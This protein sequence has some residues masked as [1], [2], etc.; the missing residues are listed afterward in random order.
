MCGIFCLFDLETAASPAARDLALK[1]AKLLRHRGPDW[2]GILVDESAVLA[3]ERL[4]IVDV[5][6]GA[7]PL[8]SAAGTWSWRSTARSTTTAPCG[9]VPR[10][11][12]RTDSDCEPIMP[13]YA[14]A[15]V[16]FLNRLQRHFRFR[17]VRQAP[18]R[19]AH[20]PRPDR[21]Q[22]LYAGR[23]ETGS[24]T[25][26]SEMKA[27]VK[28]CPVIEDF[29]PGH[30]L[31]RRDRQARPLLR[32]ATGSALRRRRPTA[33]SIRGNSGRAGDAVHSAADV[34]RALRR[35]DL[36]RLD[37]SLVAAWP[38]G[39]RGSG[40]R[41]ATGV[42]PGGRGST[43]L[44]S[45]WRD[46]PTWP[47]PGAAAR[48]RQRPPRVSSSP[49]GGAGRAERCHLSHRMLRRRRRSAPRRRCS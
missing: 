17:P 10:L 25:V 44:R 31:T 7:Q 42:R 13:L 15:R 14:R 2:S 35:A 8:T 23:D 37:S 22:P 39:S 41:R 20:R 27:L 45:G 4:A 33:S 30:Y 19:L 43:R 16:K 28:F 18:E 3:H 9:G 26:A 5:Q 24:L 1:A 32:P 49:A 11:P 29:P 48:D 21:G 47:P 12:L 46:L 38:R 40:S 34:R 36:R 6:H